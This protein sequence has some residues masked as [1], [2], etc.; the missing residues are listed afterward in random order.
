[1]RYSFHFKNLLPKHNITSAYIFNRNLF[2]MEE[3][4]DS[5]LENCRKILPVINE[6][7]HKGLSGRI[8]VFG[9]S[10]E[11]TGAP[12]YAGISA[13]RT[14]ADLVYVFSASSAAPVIKSYSPE[15]MVLP[16]LDSEDAMELISPWLIRLHGILIGPGLGRNEKTF[17][18]IQNLISVLKSSPGQNGS[19]RPIVLDAD[20]LFFLSKCPDI[21]KDYPG[22]VYLTPNVVEFKNLLKSVL[23]VDVSEN[24]PPEVY[25]EE[26]C[27]EIGVNVTI[28]LKG[29]I[30]MICNTDKILQCKSEGSFRRCGGQG[31]LLSGILCTFVSWVAIRRSNNLP[32]IMDKYTDNML[33]GY[34]ACSI[35]RAC[36][37]TAFQLRGR[38]M[39]TTDMISEFSR[40]YSLLFNE[41]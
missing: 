12:Y 9:G 41:T 27:K 31:D 30:D 8:G 2:S 33:A 25:I 29:K 24:K 16:Y 38:T 5:L 26:L 4:Q 10:V 32:Q 37:K 1:M 36:N 3:A 19:F 35:T 15:L 23:N 39:L 20:A 28:V 11:F 7:S 22:D 34:S 18:V 17:T 13:L 21:L 14:G 40:V 6:N